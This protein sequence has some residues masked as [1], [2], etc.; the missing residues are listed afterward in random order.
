MG[1]FAGERS[2]QLRLCCNG[3]NP[4]LGVVKHSSV[5]WSLCQSCNK[6]RHVVM[7][8]L[9]SE[10]C[11]QNWSMDNIRQ[12]PN[13]SGK[14]Q[15]DFRSTNKHPVTDPTT[16]LARWTTRDLPTLCFNSTLFPCRRELL[17]SDQVGRVSWQNPSEGMLATTE[18]TLLTLQPCT[19]IWKEQSV[20][21]L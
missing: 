2:T 20:I 13:L 12:Q 7:L 16:A 8:T 3:C 17:A 5:S 21:I 10:F 11:C 1:T 18:A 19:M 4:D 9:G 6:N 15:T 14:K